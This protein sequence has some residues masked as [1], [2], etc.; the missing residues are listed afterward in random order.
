M[1]ESK[2]ETTIDEAAARARELLREITADFINEH[3]EELIRRVEEKL[4]L[5]QAAAQ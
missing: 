4:K 3:R 2:G 5:E 1:D